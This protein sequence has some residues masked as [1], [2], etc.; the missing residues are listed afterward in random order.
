MNV[1]LKL[2]LHPKDTSLYN[3]QTYQNEIKWNPEHFWMQTV[4]TGATQSILSLA[5]LLV[6]MAYWEMWAI[7]WKK[8]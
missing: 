1:G 2:G 5:I 6:L 4:G 7:N 3:M 8:S